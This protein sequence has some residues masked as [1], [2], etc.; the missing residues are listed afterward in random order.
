MREF[1]SI[2]I[3]T[4]AEKLSLPKLHDGKKVDYGD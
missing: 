1:V 4:K 3:K 2:S